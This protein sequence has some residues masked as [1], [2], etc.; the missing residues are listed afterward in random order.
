MTGVPAVLAQ[1]GSP[2]PPP[3]A[4][5]VFTEM[6]CNGEAPLVYQD[7]EE[8]GA[9]VTVSVDDQWDCLEHA[10]LLVIGPWGG[11]FFPAN[12]HSACVADGRQ[13]VLQL[14]DRT[15]WDKG[16]VWMLQD[17]NIA[18]THPLAGPCGTV[19]EGLADMFLNPHQS[20][21]V[22]SD[23]DWAFSRATEILETPANRSAYCFAY[24][25][26]LEGNL[27]CANWFEHFQQLVLEFQGP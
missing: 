16:S 24:A 7:V 22:P 6:V 25:G 17:D 2:E 15:G 14:R 12:A 9:G 5:G 1:D 10:A 27:L 19:V 8:T 4:P 20:Y 13:D 11:T 3:G 18:L 26:A 21:V 23:I